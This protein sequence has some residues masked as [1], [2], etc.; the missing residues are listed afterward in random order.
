MSTDENVDR[1]IKQ[2]R[3]EGVKKAFEKPE[4]GT[5]Q[6]PQA[7]EPVGGAEKAGESVGR[8]G[9]DVAKK[10]QESGRHHT[11]DDGS[12]AQRPTGE[13]NLRDVSALRD[14]EE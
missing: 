2:E 3:A 11:G 13:S 12:P 7:S 8:R 10:E 5:P 6:E 14:N 9:E 1:S 4:Q